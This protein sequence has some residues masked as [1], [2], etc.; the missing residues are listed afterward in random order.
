[1]SVR[2]PPHSLTQGDLTKLTIKTIHLHHD[3][4]T[5]P[6]NNTFAEHLDATVLAKVV[7]KIPSVERVL[8]QVRFAL[9]Q[10]ECC[11]VSEGRPLPCLVAN[12]AVAF[13]CACFEIEGSGEF[14]CAAV[15]AP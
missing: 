8:G 2:R 13:E 15:A 10:F 9:K 11:W 1:M 12:R 14:D 3:P 5:H 4:L 6:R 7:H